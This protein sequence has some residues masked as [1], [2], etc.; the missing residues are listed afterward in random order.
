MA[1]LRSEDGTALN[2]LTDGDERNPAL[3]FIHGYAQTAVAWQ[4]QVAA[5]ADDFFVVRLDLRG[6]GDSGK[7]ADPRAYSES[8]RWADDVAVVIRDLE[9]RTPI[10]IGW[11][12]GGYVI[13]DYLRLYGQDAIAG[14]VLAGGVS[15]RGV[16]P[17]ERFSDPALRHVWRQL[18]NPDDAVALPGFVAFA[19]AC[20]AEPPPPEVLEAIA[21]RSLRLPAHARRA[22]VSRTVDSAQTWAEYG[23]PLLIIHGELDRMVLPASA[24]WHAAQVPH[25]RSLRYAGVGH[26][27]FIEA[28]ERFNADLRAFAST[29]LGSV[30]R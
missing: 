18:M 13:A 23:K 8:Q 25:A 29:V 20:F 26:S 3:V 11:S 30:S 9:L 17:G 12:Y 28:T 15:L 19:E 14:V 21:K 2:V 27:P 10:L 7:P 1:T 5:F 4:P 16:P 22:M 6:H 24:D